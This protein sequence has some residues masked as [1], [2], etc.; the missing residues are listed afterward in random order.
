M[1]IDDEKDLYVIDPDKICITLKLLTNQPINGIYIFHKI[2][3]DIV[4]SLRIDGFWPGNIIAEMSEDLASSG[5]YLVFDEPSRL[6]PWLS[7]SSVP[8]A[9]IS[10]AEAESRTVRNASPIVKSS[11]MVAKC[12]TDILKKC[13]FSPFGRQ[14]SGVPLLREDSRVENCR[15]LHCA[16]NWKM[17]EARRNVLARGLAITRAHQDPGNARNGHQGVPTW[18]LQFHRDGFHAR[19]LPTKTAGAVVPR[20]KMLEME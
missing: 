14:S 15:F 1:D 19:L 17:P 10:F 16:A 6:Y 11:F 7:T 2:S 4:P 3:V 12:L 13:S 20:R 8:H 18:V 5:C 9:R